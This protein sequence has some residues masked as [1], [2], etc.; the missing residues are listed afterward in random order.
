MKSE[1]YSWRLEPE[2]KM[3]LEEAARREHV[4]VAQLLERITREWLKARPG[5]AEDEAEQERIRASAMRFI[6]KLRGDDPDRSAMV[7][8]RVREQLARKRAR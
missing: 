8:Q 7:S 3:R 2:L 5:A 4:S 6:G 1:V